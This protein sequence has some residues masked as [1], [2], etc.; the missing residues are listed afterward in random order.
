MLRQILST[1]QKL[2]GDG[3]IATGEARYVSV[4][5]TTTGHLGRPVAQHTIIVFQGLLYLYVGDKRSA[6]TEF[7]QAYGIYYTQLVSQSP[8]T[9]HVRSPGRPSQQH[10]W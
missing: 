6:K 8:V 9:P 1:R 3:H 2:L 7:E 5:P 4:S 10:Q